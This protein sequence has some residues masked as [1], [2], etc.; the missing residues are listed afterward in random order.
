MFTDFNADE[1]FQVGVEIEKNGKTFYET[2]AGQTGDSTAREL[3]DRLAQWE[4]QHIQLFEDL[5]RRLPED[6]KQETTFDPEGEVFSY[7]KAAAQNHVFVKNK[8]ARALARQCKSPQDILDLA[9][10]FE[11]DSIAFYT[12]MRKVVP[13]HLGQKEVDRLIDEEVQHVALLTEW[14]GKL[15]GRK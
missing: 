9:V 8:D 15:P 6:A 3:F 10:T 5:K 7:I 14:K 4:H 11:K 1:I 13:V 2:A 12:A